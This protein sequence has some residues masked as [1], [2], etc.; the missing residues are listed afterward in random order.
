MSFTMVIFFFTLGKIGIDLKF[1]DIN[2]I[3]PYFSEKALR[4]LVKE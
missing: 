2:K 1:R 3:S 4:R